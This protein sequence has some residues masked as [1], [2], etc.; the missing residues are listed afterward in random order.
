MTVITKASLLAALG[1]LF[2]NPDLL[3]EQANEVDCD[4]ARGCEWAYSE[5]G[6]NVCGCSKRESGEPCSNALAEMLRNLAALSRRD[7]EIS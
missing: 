6:T 3:E 5:I 4:G 1:D 2:L 7:G